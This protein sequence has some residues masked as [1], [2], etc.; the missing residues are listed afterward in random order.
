MDIRSQL[1]L[2][3]TARAVHGDEGEHIWPEVQF[4]VNATSVKLGR[5]RSS[6][7]GAKSARKE[8]KDNR[9]GF[10]RVKDEEAERWAHVLAMT[11]AARVLA[12]SIAIVKDRKIK[13]FKHIE[14]CQYFTAIWY[15]QAHH[16]DG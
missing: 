15:G 9:R 2:V 5:S 10:S 6:V 16:A 11:S 13:V 7:V 14:V 4:N 8:L 12:C 1:S 3:V